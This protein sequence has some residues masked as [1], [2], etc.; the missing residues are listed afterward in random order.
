MNRPQVRESKRDAVF[1]PNGT[2]IE[3]KTLNL[4]EEKPLRYSFGHTNNYRMLQIVTNAAPLGEW[5]IV[6]RQA[7]MTRVLTAAFEFARQYHVDVDADHHGYSDAKVIRHWHNSKRSQ[8]MFVEL[9]NGEG[10]YYG[11]PQH[12]AAPPPTHTAPPA[13][14]DS[15]PFDW[16]TAPNGRTSYK[17]VAGDTLSA[18]ALKYY[19]VAD[20]QSFAAIAL[21]NPKKFNK[22]TSP[23]STILQPACLLGPPGYCRHTYVSKA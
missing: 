13:P 9:T 20:A 23:G 10:I 14:T 6:S 17:V 8:H 3:R 11:R 2:S 15:G 7:L 22:T 5:R 18:V 1:S 21:A 19:G 12:D 16:T 4:L